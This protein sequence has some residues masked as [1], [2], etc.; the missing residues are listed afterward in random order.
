MSKLTEGMDMQIVNCMLWFALDAPTGYANMAESIKKEGLV[1]E[2]NVATIMFYIQIVANL[3]KL[4]SHFQ[5]CLEKPHY[6][7][8]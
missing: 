3:G 1:A 4:Y 8:T 2:A 7:E 6:W 5:Q